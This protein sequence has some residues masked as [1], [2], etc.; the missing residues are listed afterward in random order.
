MLYRH[1]GKPDGYFPPILGN[2]EITLSPDK[3][4]VLCYDRLDYGEKNEV[5]DAVIFRAGRRTPLTHSKA[6]AAGGKL[7]SFGKCAFDCGE[8]PARWTQE[9]LPEEGKQRMVCTYP[10]GEEIVTTALVHPQH[11]VYAMKK[12]F[13]GTAR[14]VCFSY[15]LCGYDEETE[16][17]ILH[18]DIVAEENGARVKLTMLGLDRYVGEVAVFADRP[19][20]VETAGKT[21]TLRMQ[22]KARDTVAL[23]IAIADD[24]Y[25]EDAAAVN[26]AVRAHI[27]A[28]GFDGLEKETAQHFA[29]FFGE[30]F[31]ATG[32]DKIDSV[33]RTALYHLLCYTT[34]WSIPVGLNNCSWHG[35]F[36]AFDE[37]YSF[38][39][40]LTANRTALAKHV[41]D[42]RNDVC[43]DKA[44]YRATQSKTEE[45]AHFFWETNEYGEEMSPPGFW[46]DH[47]FHMAVV[48][49]G[50]YQY[51]AFTQDKPY[52][53]HCYRLIRACAKFYTMHMLYTDSNGRVY[54][55]KCTD[56]ERLGASVENPFMT[57][58]G[59]I[60]TL[61]CL[62]KAADALNTDRDYRNECAA[63]AVKLRESLPREN[64]AYVP[65][66]GCEQKSIAVFSGKFPFDV[67]QN[68]D[69]CLKPAWDAFI[70]EESAFGNMYRMGKHISPWYACW[71]AEGFARMGMAEDAYAALLQA[72]PST[73]EFDE[74]FEINEPG[75]LY[76][77]WF[78]T[79]AG[80][81][82]STVNEMLLQ[83][84]EEN[85]YLMPAFP[86]T[87]KPVSFRL[88]AK[89]GAIVEATIKGE[90]LESLQVTMR[91]GV[92]ARSYTVYLRG[93]KLDTVKAQ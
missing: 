27:A 9:L 89:G 74:M 19:V 50:A 39:G 35:K 37:Y 24:L 15:T 45:Q 76:R 31:V 91:D 33:Y 90:K 71:K 75:I 47:I 61:E 14:E 32:D 30:G 34:R 86:V 8:K 80:I 10:S 67:L 66:V 11:N 12:A 38:L 81:Y 3:E 1:T 78:T 59:V 83:S 26:D 44:I 17:A 28:V 4:G 40:L 93:K 13:A 7:L 43:L 64:G 60:E 82:L 5:Q 56:L 25:G 58:C 20:K 92:P 18:T 70:K 77:P 69:P 16:N 85:L 51:Y 63:L 22:V 49:L 88:A 48:A 84:D 2:G 42:F 79:A 6:G 54:V 87:E 62:V 73:G 29:A 55:G 21:V 53:A 36:F 46:F 68:D 72:L 41:P 65:F 57:A 23:Y 52:L